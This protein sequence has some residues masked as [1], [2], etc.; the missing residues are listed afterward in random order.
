M[1]DKRKNNEDVNNYRPVTLIPVS[2]KLFE[3][4]LYTKLVGYCGL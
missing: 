3:M 4:C 1:K 2:A